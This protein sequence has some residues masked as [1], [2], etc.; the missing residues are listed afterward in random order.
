M[1]KKLCSVARSYTRSLTLGQS[2]HPQAQERVGGITSLC[3]LQLF[4]S[5]RECVHRAA[6]S[7]SVCLPLSAPVSL[8]FSYL[9]KSVQASADRNYLVLASTEN[10]GILQGRTSALQLFVKIL[11]CSLD[12]KKIPFIKLMTSEET[13][14]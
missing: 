4:F 11:K 12:Q 3:P 14:R 10:K 6:L 13:V 1:G 5:C 2:A 9:K 7:L 8:Y